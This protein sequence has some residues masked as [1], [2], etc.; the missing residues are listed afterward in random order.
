MESIKEI[1]ATRRSLDSPSLT[2]A[3]P[4]SS[5]TPLLT[6]ALQTPSPTPK[7]D[8]E[9]V[10]RT[11]QDWT[12]DLDQTKPLTVKQ[13]K[14]QQK[15][16]L[17]QKQPNSS[18]LE[19]EEQQS[20]QQIALPGENQQAELAAAK[21]AGRVAGPENSVPRQQNH[22]NKTQNEAV[23]IFSELMQTD[24]VST[25]AAQI[26]NQAELIY[27]AWK[28]TGLN[29][30]ELIQY[31]S[32]SSDGGR[33]DS[34]ATQQN[35]SITSQSPNSQGGTSNPGSPLGRS[36]RSIS[37]APP[38]SSPAIPRRVLDTSLSN[39]RPNPHQSFLQQELARQ[40]QLHQQHLQAFQKHHQQIQQQHQQFI[41]QH[42]LQHALSPIRTLNTSPKPYVPPT[43]SPA[44]CTGSSGGGSPITVSHL[45]HP[46]PSSPGGTLLQQNSAPR[47][48]VSPNSASQQSPR[49]STTFQSYPP[50][51]PER[52]SSY[53]GVDTPQA[54]PTGQQSTS[55]DILAD[56]DLEASLQDLVNTFVLEDKARHAGVPATRLNERPKSAPSTI[57]DALQ[58]FERQMAITSRSAAP[59]ATQ[60]EQSE[61]VPSQ[62][63]VN[64]P[65][66]SPSGG[67]SRFSP[68]PSNVAT[69]PG[70]RYV[71]SRSDSAI[72]SEQWGRE[73]VRARRSISPS[74]PPVSQP[75]WNESPPATTSTWPLKNKQPVDPKTKQPQGTTETRTVS[76]PTAAA[77][78]S[79][80][81]Q[82]SS[83]NYITT[84]ETRVES[85]GT[86]NNSTSVPLR[87]KVVT[88][89][90]V[91]KE[92]ERLL[93][94]LRTGTVIE[95]GDH[96]VLN[97]NSPSVL[98]NTSN[99]GGIGSFSNSCTGANSG[100]K[101]KF[102]ISVTV[103]VDNQSTT[104][105]GH[106]ISPQHV[107]DEMSVPMNTSPPS[108]E[109]NQMSAIDYAKV[110]FQDAQQRPKTAQ[111][112]E[113]YKTITAKPVVNGDGRVMMAR[114][115]FENSSGVVVE[116]PWR[117][118]STL[119]ADEVGST[120][121]EFYRRKLRKM[122]KSGSPE[123][124][125]GALAALPHPELTDQQKAHIRER[126]QSPTTGALFNSNVAIRPFLTQGSV[127][128]RVMIFER[129]PTD[130]KKT[131]S[132][133]PAA[134]PPERKRPA[135]S[136]WRDPDEVRSKAQV[137]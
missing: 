62:P 61:S 107:S 94:A 83:T 70:R 33:L 23:T 28:T 14:E 27:Q 116:A 54:T 91:D 86:S 30:S 97:P 132:G 105:S 82:P 46:S 110:R 88:M 24:D 122:R 17:L 32:V 36:I 38:G 124:L 16:K 60:I 40:Q 66:G 69:A 42:Q 93:H 65:Y 5:S 123:P 100:R 128:E 71:G 127:A 56:T 79:Q 19:Q 67:T 80:G 15:Q 92:E 1:I 108:D 51:P 45:S 126:S 76:N 4:T 22:P 73:D 121:P 131:T 114:N 10:V 115:R 8:V 137:S 75:G 85:S 106:Q 6:Y 53:T 104:D 18:T 59:S 96:L 99:T 50:A 68:Q 49:A 102:S 72:S 63:I 134:L 90:A 31:H 55:I 44:S 47:P 12:N 98:S 118:N 58:R 130:M 64:P 52:S 81:A 112:L 57:Q 39:G 103:D 11:V 21:R 7:I 34:S 74:P 84:L 25:I 119:Q 101:P 26:A 135:I 29:P 77:L 125:A 109:M 117:N 129:A 43:S 9:S 37:P 48:Y 78:S 13:I 89:S 133:I 2:S 113:D 20:Q 3:P 111:R 95:D 35:P 136:S 41:Q 87:H 120:L